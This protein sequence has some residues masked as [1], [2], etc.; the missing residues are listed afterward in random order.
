VQPLLAV[1]AS[2]APGA[3]RRYPEAS[4]PEEVDRLMNS[5]TDALPSPRR[6]YAVVRLALDLGRDEGRVA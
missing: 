5:F 2:P 1:I 3:W 6:G 4:K